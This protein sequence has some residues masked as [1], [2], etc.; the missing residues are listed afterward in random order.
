MTEHKTDIIITRIEKKK[1]E[2]NT[3]EQKKDTNINKNEKY[4][5]KIK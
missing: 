1:K 3:T 5:K 4:K 2:M